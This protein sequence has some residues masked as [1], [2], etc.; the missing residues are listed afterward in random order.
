MLVHLMKQIKML[1]STKT[2]SNVANLFFFLHFKVQQ[3]STSYFQS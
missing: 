1:P 2:V 3:V